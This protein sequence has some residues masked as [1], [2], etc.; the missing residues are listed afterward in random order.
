MASITLPAITA[1]A[2]AGAVERAWALFEEA[3]YHLASAEPAALAVKGRLL[4]DRARLAPAGDRAFLFAKAASAY[5]EACLIDPAPYLAINAATARLLSGDQAGAI[6]GARAV[7]GLLDGA[8]TPVDTPYYLAATRA[9]ALLLLG[10]DDRAEQALAEAAAQNPDGWDDRAVTL[11]QLRAIGAA[12]HRALDWLDRFAPP[13]SLH[14]AGHM[15]LHCD[16]TSERKLRGDLDRLLDEIRPGFAWGALAAGVDLVVAEQLLARGCL[17]HA[18]L[19]CPPEQF[20]AQ[21]VAP[22][23]DGWLARYRQVLDQVES[24]QSA[25]PAASSVHDPIATAHAGELAIGGAMLNARRLSSQAIQLVICDE[26]GG[27]TNTRRQAELWAPEAGRQIHVTAVR[28]SAVEA[29]FPPERPDPNRALAVHVAIGIEHNR[30]SGV[31][32]SDEIEAAQAPFQAAL[33][34]LAPTAVRA[35][36][37]T[38]ELVFTDLDQALGTVSRVL[39]ATGADGSLAAIGVTLAIATLHHDRASNSLVPF[40]PGPA[41]ARRLQAMAAP[42]TALASNAL[43][44]AMTARGSTAMRSELYHFGDIELGGA[45]HTLL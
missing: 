14:F 42:G 19:P 13:P 23:G 24:I 30:W 45:V 26:E 8:A 39:K 38:W 40:G 31:V 10:D 16:G 34:D 33:A 1:L 37:G 21:S 12:Q 32:P 2:R 7:L 44:V 35:G 5:G 15:G 20:E 28:D 4:K 18:V 43:A 41:L 36:P 6:E 27:G 17:L 3:G 11:A 22:A 9:E 29:T 25:G